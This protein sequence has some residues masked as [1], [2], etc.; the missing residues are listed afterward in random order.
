MKRLNPNTGLPF[1]SGDLRE[2]GFIFRTYNKTTILK[3]GYFLE[4]WSS[5]KSFKKHLKDC[6]NGSKNRY[7]KPRG[8]AFALLNH[9]KLRAKTRSGIVTIDREWI[10]NKLLNGF[11]ELTRLPFDFS[12]CEFNKNPYA[13][14]VDRIDCNNP[15]YT[16][17]NSRVVLFAVN[18]AL[19]EYGLDVLRPILKAL[20]DA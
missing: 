6:L 12:D 4:Y 15:N 14:S 13:P 1:K 17:E 16:P 2:D 11:C 8:R 10:E 7:K 18:T 19:N 9:A 20:L 3:N 5:P